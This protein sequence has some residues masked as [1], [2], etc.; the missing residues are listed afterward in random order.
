MKV[1]LA[2]DLQLFPKMLPGAIKKKIVAPKKNMKKMK[3]PIEYSASRHE[4]LPQLFFEV[5]TEPAKPATPRSRKTIE[6]TQRA[7]SEPVTAPLL[8]ELMISLFQTW[9]YIVTEYIQYY[10]QGVKLR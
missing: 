6:D 9:T 5:L 8:A 10:L 7:I 1:V 3:I 4:P 2:P